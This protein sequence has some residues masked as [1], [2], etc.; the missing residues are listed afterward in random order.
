MDDR[1]ALASRLLA[2]AF[3]LLLTVGGAATVAAYVLV[4][5]AAGR[6]DPVLLEADETA[7]LAAGDISAAGGFDPAKTVVELCET[8]AA[9]L[10]ARLTPQV[11]PGLPPH[12]GRVVVLNA[13]E[14]RLV[15]LGEAFAA[16][17][18][19]GNDLL[20][21]VL[22]GDGRLAMRLLGVDGGDDTANGQAEPPAPREAAGSLATVSHAPRRRL[23]VQTLTSTDLIDQAETG[24]T[25]NHETAVL[26][27]VYVIFGD[28][29]LPAAYRGNDAGAFDSL[30]LE[31]VHVEWNTYSPATQ[32]ALLPFLKP[33]AYEGS[34][35]T[36][37]GGHAHGTATDICGAL[38]VLWAWK[39]NPSGKVRVWYWAFL[40]A[41]AAKAAVLANEADAVI[42]P[43]ISGFMAP[44]Q[45]LSDAGYSCNGGSDRLDIYLSDIG[46]STTGPVGLNIYK[47]KNTPAYISLNRSE[48]AST[49]AH[50]IFHAFEYS[51]PLASC[52]TSSDYNWWTEGSAEWVMDKVYPDVNREHQSAGWLPG[53][54]GVSLDVNVDGHR[55]GTYL[56]PFY[57]YKKTGSAAFVKRVWDNCQGLDAVNAFHT[58][59]AEGW[60]GIWPE[61]VLHN[62][63][64]E[65]VHQY[66][67]W[68][69]IKLFPAKVTSPVPVTLAG[70][71]DKEY[72][73]TYDLPKLSGAY[74]HYT[75]P[76]STV[77]SVAFWNGA[78][79]DLQKTTG[80]MIS[81]YWEAKTYSGGETKGVR[82]QAL[83]K[84][85]DVWRQEDWTSLPSKFFCRDVANERIQELV[86]VI[87]D[88]Q[89]LDPGQRAKPPGL[90]PRLSVSN[91]GCYKW[92][93]TGLSTI[94]GEGGDTATA[95]V[96]DVT[97][98]REPT[99]PGD[100][101]VHY[102]A[103]GSLT[104]VVSGL[105]NGTSPP[106]PIRPDGLS[107][108][109]TANYA[110]VDTANR[111]AYWGVGVMLG[112]T[113]GVECPGWSEP[114]PVPQWFATFEDPFKFVSPDGTKIHDTVTGAGGVGTF[115]VNLTSQPEP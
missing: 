50:E 51:L 6:A 99:F 35:A 64:T 36:P 48:S 26:Y 19:V 39:E 53:Q 93:G 47:C 11:P 21:E 5:G 75:F 101:S 27:R 92:K 7:R 15:R 42:W 114:A 76:D 8:A 54:P 85:K 24:G 37:A 22:E 58:A 41:D 95:N 68:D 14:C 13:G 40:S 73:I 18:L 79:F 74:E 115:T 105:C 66:F 25:L 12:G 46:R 3:G 94:V 10:V 23:E 113:F 43:N 17:D 55:Y 80:G 52:L 82:V 62:W 2:F 30:Y 103:T 29:R 44:H 81:P 56:V 45:P 98:T 72:T 91:M 71:R 97:W 78:T 108:L 1:R 102:S 90:D 63:N 69:K 38:S 86:L 111:R 106:L 9:T 28:A 70:A 83:I 31:T 96:T 88:S 59:V 57:Y 20:V 77:R 65:P 104:A 33:P 60:D 16:E 89:F 32:A 107:F 109:Q 4:P 84:V 67:D 112:V 61:V 87:S 49:L 100:N 110:P 34:W